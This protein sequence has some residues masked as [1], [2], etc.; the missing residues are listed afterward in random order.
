M[1]MDVIVISI[2]RI[3]KKQFGK[4]INLGQIVMLTKVVKLETVK[5]L[6]LLLSVLVLAGCEKTDRTEKYQK[7]RDRVV[8]VHSRIREIDLG[9]ELLVG[10]MPRLFLMGDYLLILD[11]RSYDNLLHVIDK[12]TFAHL[13]SGIKRGRGPGEIVSPGNLIID[14]SRCKFLIPDYGKQ[15]IYGFGFHD[16]LRQSDYKPEVEMQMQAKSFPA[17]SYL[18]GDDLL[19]GIIIEPIGTSNFRESLAKWSLKNGDISPMP[20]EHPDIERRRIDFAV[21]VEKG[22]YAEVYHHHDLITIGN[23]DGTLRYNIYGPRWDAATSNAYLYYGKPLFCGDRII[24]AYS[25]EA[26]DSEGC[27]PTNFM[28]FDL[29]GNYLQTWKTGYRLSDFCY[30]AENNRLILALDEA[31]Q[32]ACL[33]LDN[34][35]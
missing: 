28:V 26:N 13:R 16:F 25:G 32:F 5:K 35:L 3:I 11:V 14:E 20:Y 21:S 34:N 12:N 1:E 2:I 8:D 15:V 22:L 17:D 29:E 33:D 10:A 6:W 23:M 24:V 31:V 7:K 27:E 9:N 30:D 19:M 18:L 4:L